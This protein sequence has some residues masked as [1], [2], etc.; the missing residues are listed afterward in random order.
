MRTLGRLAF[1]GTLAVAFAASGLAQE[2]PKPAPEMAQLAPFD[3]SWTCEGK[4][5]QTPMSPAGTMK[6]AR[7]SAS[8]RRAL[9]SGPVRIQSLDARAR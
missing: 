4:M 9:A 1:V 8:A 7:R 5:F 6:V 2:M 3:G